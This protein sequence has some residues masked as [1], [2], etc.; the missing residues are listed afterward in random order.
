MADSN[1]VSSTN[2]SP[3]EPHFSGHFGTSRG[4]S[5]PI[6]CLTINQLALAKGFE[7]FKQQIHMKLVDTLNF[8]EV[9]KLSEDKR[10]SEIRGVIQR[11]LAEDRGA[12]SDQ[13]ERERLIQELLNDTLGLGPLEDLLRDPTISDILINGPHEVY[14]ERRGKL[15]RSKVAFKDD[16]HLMHVI[17][18]IVSRIGRRVDESSPMVDARLKDGSRVNVILPPLALRG[19]TMC[20]RRFGTAPL[21]MDDLVSKKA[22]SSEMAL[23]MESAVRAR[24]NIIISGGTGSGK[25]TLLNALSSF[26]APDERIV[27]IEDA[28]E[29]QLQ[30]PHVVQLESRPPNVEGRGQVTI[31]DLVRNALRMRPDRIVIGECRGA[32][33]LDMLQAMNTG[34]EG[35]L[36]T[37]HANTPRDGLARLET[38]IMMGGFELPVK[39]MRQQIS[40]ALDLIIQVNRLQGGGR[41]VTSVTEV[42]GIEGEV[43]LMQDIFRFRQTGVSVGGEA[44]GVFEALGIRPC[45]MPRLK[46]KG[47]ELPVNMFEARMLLEA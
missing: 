11:L 15:Y 12:P 36:T 19:P 35:S 44:Q 17:D 9:L 16:E 6:D 3:T 29:L 38:L 2:A 4:D 14:I 23:F 37:L 41:R 20:I 43:I 22:L 28:A 47:V 7:Q 30:Q 24:M 34:H 5:A 18:R 10:R 40:S 27:T 39:A 33:A 8:E 32:E 46:A 21:K 25:T 31:N 42:L 13:H 1:G 26:I 45:F